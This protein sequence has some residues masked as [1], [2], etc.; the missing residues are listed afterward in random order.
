MNHVQMSHAIRTTLQRQA[1]QILFFYKENLNE[2]DFCNILGIARSQVT[3]S[4]CVI[5]Q[6]SIEKSHKN[7]FATQN[8]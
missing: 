7:P 1:L 3:I 2:Y 6:E 4:L 8:L 5:D